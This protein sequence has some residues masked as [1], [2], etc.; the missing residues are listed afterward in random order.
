MFCVSSLCRV[1]LDSNSLFANFD[2]ETCFDT[3]VSLLPDNALS[4]LFFPFVRRVYIAQ[5][6]YLP[7]DVDIDNDIGA[8]GAQALATALQ[9]NSTLTEL[10]LTSA[11][12]RLDIVLTIVALLFV[13]IMMM[14]YIRVSL[15]LVCKILLYFSWLSSC[16]CFGSDIVCYTV[17]VRAM[18]MFAL[19]RKSN[20]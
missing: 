8:A 11:L 5:F 19:C 17:V 20:R 18:L 15:C 2:I 14:I 6:V 1:F 10:S 13:F 3:F 16:E 12:N 9:Y 4:K 7:V